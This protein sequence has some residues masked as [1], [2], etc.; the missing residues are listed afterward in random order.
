MAKR[1]VVL[2]GG[3]GY[4]AGRM[5]PELR[6]RYDLTLLDIKTKNRDGEEVEGVN[7]AD[8]VN[9]DRE[10]YR[11][12]FRG[13]D[14]VIHCGWVRHSE[15]GDNFWVER[16]NITMAYNVYQTS[17]EESVRRVVVISSNHAADFYERLIWSDQMGYDV[18]PDLPPLSDNFYGWGKAAYELL[19]FVFASG[20]ATRDHLS[21]F[22]LGGHPGLQNVQIRIG[23]PKEK[24]ILAC[25]PDDLKT[26]RRYLGAYLSARDQVQLIVKSIETENIENEHGVPFQIFY[27]ISGNTHSF[28]NITNARKVIGYAPQDDS[29][30]RFSEKVTEI[31]TAAKKEGQH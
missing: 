15:P 21:H 5:L 13:A 30:I 19:G 7:I 14:A 8:L 31:I 1:K 12:H 25:E 23:S 28:W 18:T 26:F 22:K 24:I 10:G 9:N 4:V 3:A 17:L 16:D 20:G 29:Q 6:K 11:G 2:T 27:G